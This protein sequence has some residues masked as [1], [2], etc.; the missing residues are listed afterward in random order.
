MQTHRDR[1]VAGEWRRNRTRRRV[2][3]H[4]PVHHTCTT[5]HHTRTHTHTDPPSAILPPRSAPS[6]GC[7][8]VIVV[9]MVLMLVMQ[10]AE[11]EEEKVVVGVEGNIG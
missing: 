11:K 4:A 7:M 10:V 5:G 2:L 8:M 3:A 1:W 6:N 9:R